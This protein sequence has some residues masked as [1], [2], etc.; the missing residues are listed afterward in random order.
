MARIRQARRCSARRKDGQPCGN[1]AI[2]GGRVC[3]I[4]G[5]AAPQVRR[6]A[7]ERL[8]MAACYRALVRLSNSRSARE[9]QEMVEAAFPAADSERR[10]IEAA[11]RR[12]EATA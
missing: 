12:F 8:L 5:G 9:H 11:A 3:R 4:H 7:K 1:Y 2:I 10:F 6:K